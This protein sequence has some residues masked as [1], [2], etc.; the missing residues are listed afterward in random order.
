MRYNNRGCIY[1]PDEALLRSDRPRI[2]A[3]IAPLLEL[4]EQTK[5]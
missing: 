1:Q 3:M 5:E 4:D 2:R